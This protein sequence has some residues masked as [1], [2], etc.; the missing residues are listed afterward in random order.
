MTTRVSMLSKSRASP[1][2]GKQTGLKT[3]QHP[4]GCKRIHICL[5]VPNFPFMFRRALHQPK[6]ELRLTCSKLP[7]FYKTAILIVPQSIIYIMCT[8]YKATYSY[9][10]LNLFLKQLKSLSKAPQ[11]MLTVNSCCQFCLQQLFTAT[12]IDVHSVVT[13]QTQL[14][15]RYTGSGQLHNTSACVLKFKLLIFMILVLF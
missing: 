1:D 15:Y 2:I 11:Y 12:Y 9:W 8:L 7:A 13:L 6:E 10:V 5:F 4:L 3:Y 14:L